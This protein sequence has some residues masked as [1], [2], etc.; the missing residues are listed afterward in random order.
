M[1]HRAIW[2]TKKGQSV[3]DIRAAHGGKLP[4]FS[5]TELCCLEEQVADGRYLLDLQ[6][7]PLWLD[8]APSK[9]LLFPV[10]LQL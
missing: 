3:Q 7:S 9:P 10:Q 2:R 5:V 6:I 4:P 1:A 8:A